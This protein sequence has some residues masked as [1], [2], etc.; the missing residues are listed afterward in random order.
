MPIREVARIVNKSEGSVKMLQA[1]AIASLTRQMVET[2][3]NQ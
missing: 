2:G 3:V 1:R